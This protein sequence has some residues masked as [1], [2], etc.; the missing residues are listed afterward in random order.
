MKNFKNNFKDKSQGFILWSVEFSKR[1]IIILSAAFLIFLIYSMVVPF[2]GITISDILT[3]ELSNVFK[4]TVGAYLIKSVIENV[5]RYNKF[6][7][8]EP[9][10]NYTDNNNYL[11]NNYSDGDSA[12]ETTEGDVDNE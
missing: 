2:F 11:D 10:G 5:F 7:F 1:L 12:E 6:S 9:N 8:S 3:Q 4:V